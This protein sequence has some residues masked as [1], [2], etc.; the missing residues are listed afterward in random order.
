MLVALRAYLIKLLG[1]QQFVKL[2][3]INS[4]GIET[5]LDII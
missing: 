4:Y 1:E 5:I 2:L 3:L